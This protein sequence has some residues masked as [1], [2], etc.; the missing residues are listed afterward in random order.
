[1]SFLDGW[2]IHPSGVP[3]HWRTKQGKC[4][5]PEPAIAVFRGKW[6]Q[7]IKERGWTV[8]ATLPMQWVVRRL[9]ARRQRREGA[10]LAPT[11]VNLDLTMERWPSFRGGG[12]QRGIRRENPAAET[13]DGDGNGAC[14]D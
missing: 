6:F 13:A 2:A 14:P 9:R 5:F 12:R 10:A 3:D 7:A 4:L 11:R 8:K 1:M